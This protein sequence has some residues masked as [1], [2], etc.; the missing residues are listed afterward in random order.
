[1]VGHQ[2]RHGD[3]GD[4]DFARF[5][6]Q[7]EIVRCDGGGDGRAFGFPVGDQRVDT[8]CIKNRTRQDMRANFGAFFKHNHIEVC[9]ELFEPDRRRK[10]RRTRAHDDHIKFHSFAFNLCHCRTLLRLRNIVASWLAQA[11][12]RGQL[13][14][15]VKTAIAR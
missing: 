5:A 15:R 1:M 2:R 14:H 4:T 11:V 10:P 8:G 12:M 6:Q 9:I 3:V 7:I 13:R